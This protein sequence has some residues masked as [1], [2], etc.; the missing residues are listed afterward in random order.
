[1]KKISILLIFTAF[2]A[3]NKNTNAQITKS[4]KVL[5]AENVQSIIPL[6]KDTARWSAKSN[7]E[8]LME[9]GYQFSPLQIWNNAFKYDIEK[10]FSSISSAVLSGKLKAYSDFPTLG[11]ELTPKEFNSILVKWDTT[12][13]RITALD[14]TG[15]SGEIPI[16]TPIKRVLKSDDITR[17]KFNEKIEFD[18][19]YYTL[20]KKVSSI[21]FFTYKINERGEQL[22]DEE[23]FYVKLNDIPIKHEN[24]NR[25]KN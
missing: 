19:V 25:Q 4:S 22:G 23:I 24:S 16:G 5:W 18:T 2:I 13:T 3:S 11:K 1:M 14:T 6:D 9:I 15:G 7:R 21:S 12:D 10:I 20:C 8:R 17:L